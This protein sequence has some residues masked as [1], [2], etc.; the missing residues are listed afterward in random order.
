MRQGCLRSSCARLVV[1]LAAVCWPAI[2]AAR[3][4][5][6][7]EVKLDN[8]VRVTAQTFVGCD[9]RFDEKGD[10]HII[11]RGYKVDLSARND[12]KPSPPSAGAP[13]PR[14]VWLISKQ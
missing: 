11:A 12:T 4:V 10:I 7:N 3:D 2:A 13:A 14:S 5:Y 1:M 8:N 9:V 6:L